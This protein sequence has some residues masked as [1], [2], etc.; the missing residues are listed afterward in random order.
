MIASLVLLFLGFII[1]VSEYQWKGA[2]LYT[3]LAGFIQ[4]PLRKLSEVDSSYFAAI[5]L[6]FFLL[7][8]LVLKSSQKRWNLD[9]I[10]WLNPAIITFLPVFFYL[11]VLQSLNSFARFSDFRLSIVGILFYIIPLISL[12]VGFNIACDLKFLR[13]VIIVYVILC[14]LTAFTILLNLWGLE[15]NLF[16]EVGPGIE[17]TGTGTGF[18]GFWRTSE[19]AG[20]HLAAGS[21]FSFIL[22]MTETKSFQQILY[23]ML[24]LG[25]SFLTITTGRRKSLGL[26]IIFASLFLLYYSFNIKGN[27]FTRAIMSFLGVAVISMSMYGLIFSSE[28]Q[29]ALEPF[30]DRSTTLTVEESQDRFQVQGIGAFL[31]GIQ[32]A[33]PI[34]YGLGVGSNAGNT[35]IGEARQ[36]IRSIGYISEGGAG[37]LIIELGIIGLA[38][39]TYL[40]IQAIILYFRNFLLSRKL[41]NFGSDFLVG[42]TLFALANMVTFVS[43]SQLYS[44][45][46]VLIMIGIC[47]G[48]FLSIPY[49]YQVFNRSSQHNID[50][51]YRNV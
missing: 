39:L 44:D 9:L 31:R 24:S 23:F 10:C 25:M 40:I 14:S 38:I 3:I 45:P 32:V 12:W 28:T 2:I 15:S 11:L 49:L 18:S 30:L 4:D 20:W 50:P 26:V 1:I 42:L 5:S 34:G 27:K 7:T 6:I 33:G 29:T 47:L 41:L 17:I 21:C 8:F 51:R 19:I 36:E 48:S 35:G 13:Q 22:G 37:R 43:A 46:F 16:N